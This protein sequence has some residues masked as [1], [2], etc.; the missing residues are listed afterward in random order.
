MSIFLI[1]LAAGDSK[2][3]NSGKPK[4]F[5]K[6]NNKTLLEH[7]LNNFKNIKEIKKI[8]LVYNKKH[9]SY[10][11]KLKLKNI[12][13]IIGGNSRQE[14]VFIALKKIKKMGCKKVLIHDAARPLTSKLIIKNL[15]NKLKKKPCSYT[16]NKKL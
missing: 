10:L 9:R 8:I 2:R 13:K 11:N 15:I 5:C 12:V 4:P 14:S 3:L 1:L 6:V 7:S 16:C